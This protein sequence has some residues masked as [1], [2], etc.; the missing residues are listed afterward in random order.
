MVVPTCHHLEELG[1]RPRRY[2]N[3]AGGG[4]GADLKQNLDPILV[5]LDLTIFLLTCAS[6]T[7]LFIVT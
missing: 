3:E 1:R 2:V 7:F 5:R 6:L 4:L